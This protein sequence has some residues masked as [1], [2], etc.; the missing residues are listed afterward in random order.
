M[1]YIGKQ[2][3]P[4]PL[5]AGDLDDDIIT[6]AKL[7]SGTDGNLITYDA[8]GNPVAVATGSDGQILTSAGAGQPCA[9]EAAPGGGKIGQVIQTVDTTLRST[10]STSFVTT[11]IAVTI[12]P[13]ATSSKILLTMDGV[14]GYDTGL[15]G[16]MTPYKAVGGASAAAL[17]VPGSLNCFRGFGESDGATGAADAIGFC[18]LDSPATTSELVYTMYWLTTGSNAHI[19]KQKSSPRTCPT[20]FTAMEVLA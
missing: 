3:T 4:V 7:A 9:F 17:T 15:D 12:T 5:T 16:M 13:S 10:T 19:G 18:Y 6:L 1:A 20:M 8:S 14:I 11:G 2:P